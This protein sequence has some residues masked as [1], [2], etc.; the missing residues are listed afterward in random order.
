MH[1]QRHIPAHIQIQCIY[2]YIHIHAGI[3]TSTHTYI[4]TN[5]HTE[6]DTLKHGVFEANT[7]KDVSVCLSLRNGSVVKST[8][9]SSNGSEFNSQQP[10]GGS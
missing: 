9:C 5:A 7:L 1:T 6:T 10:H 2:T 4:N 8:D 3:H